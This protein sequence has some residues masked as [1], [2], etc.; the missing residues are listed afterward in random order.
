MDYTYENLMTI[1]DEPITEGK[2]MDTY[3]A[4]DTAIENGRR[5]ISE[6]N[7]NIKGGRYDAA[8]KELQ[9]AKKSF[10][11]G[12]D[13]INKVPGG[14]LADTIIQGWAKKTVSVYRMFREGSKLQK[15]NI[16]DPYKDWSENLKSVAVMRVLNNIISVIPIPPV[17]VYGIAGNVGTDY[18]RRYRNTQAAKS[19]GEKKPFTFNGFKEDLVWMLN[20]YIDA[21][22]ALIKNVRNQKL[23]KSRDPI[24]NES[25]YSDKIDELLGSF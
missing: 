7:K 20:A 6:A 10:K 22:D 18:G 2:N 14:V 1:I 13:E 12:I 25:Y 24:A 3:D 23:Y 16:D 19:R 9:E 21:T 17:A 4:F 5:C 8:L 11:N 15:Y